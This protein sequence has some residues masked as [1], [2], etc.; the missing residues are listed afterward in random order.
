MILLYS[1]IIHNRI[2]TII[3]VSTYEHSQGTRYVYK[4]HSYGVNV[5]KNIYEM[6]DSKLLNMFD[7]C[8]TAVGTSSQQLIVACNRYVCMNNPRNRLEG[9]FSMSSRSTLKFGTARPMTDRI[10][11]F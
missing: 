3:L 10:H 9:P 1:E 7:E 8:H 5:K 4:L 2:H 6:K 11:L